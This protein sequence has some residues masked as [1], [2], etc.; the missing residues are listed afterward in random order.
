MTGLQYDCVVVV[1]VEVVVADLIVW[2][3]HIISC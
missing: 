1:M 2:P 3:E